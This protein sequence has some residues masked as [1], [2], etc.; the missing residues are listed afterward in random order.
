MKSQIIKI[1]LGNVLALFLFAGSTVSQE[2]TDSSSAD[3]IMKKVKKTLDGMST[4]SCHFEWN[5]NWKSA[6]RTQNFEGTIRLKNPSKMRVEYSARTIVID[7]K[8]V[9]SYSP[10]NKQVEI[11][12]FVSEEK[13][14]PTPQGI[15]K[16]YAQRKAVLSGHE[17]LNGRETNVITLASPDGSGKDVTVWVDTLLN[18]PLKTEE[19]SP[20]GDVSTYI[21]SDVRI[22][23]KISDSVFAFSAPEG[24]NVVDMR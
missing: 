10:K 11:T 19:E 14:F 1:F 20:N 17:R 9:W 23:S 2:Q 22:N 3:Q 13:A 4:L 5:H 8:T 6:D 15:F 21:L 16:R 7:G 24:T 18:F 12:K